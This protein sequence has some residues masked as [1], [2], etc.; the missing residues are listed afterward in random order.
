M[1][2]T[3]RSKQESERDKIV[4]EWGSLDWLADRGI[5][6]ANDLTIGRCIIKKGHSNPR[7]YHTN[8]EE[9]LY[10]L[11]GRLR[12][13]IGDKD[14]IVEPGDTLVV[15]PGDIHNAVSIGE[16]DADMIVAYP[17]VRDFHLEEE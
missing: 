14:I 11:R 17:G 8:G 10:L 16:E 9:V 7:H 15:S 6:N 12:H 13:S 1:S 2:Y 4:E 5:G 3:L